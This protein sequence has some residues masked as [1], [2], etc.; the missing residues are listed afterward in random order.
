MLPTFINVA[1]FAAFALQGALADFTIDTPTF[2]QCQSAQVTWS[3]TKA[4]YNLVI[5]AAADPCG[6]YLAD[7]GD[8]NGTSMT[9]KVALAAGSQVQLS[10]EDASGDEAWSGTIT[11]AQ[12]SDT[13]CLPS[14]G[15]TTPT[16][17]TSPP[18]P[19]S[20]LVVV[21]TT[22]VDASPN[23]PSTVG[24]AGAAGATPS[25]NGAPAIHASMP[26]MILGAL[27]AVVA[28]SL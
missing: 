9:Y 8:H 22:T 19:G 12:S 1:L 28:T 17:T 18:V 24:A 3:T 20:T 21:P 11:V 25:S 23:P 16:T 27:A 14:N 26:I 5:V 10:L 7:L 4:P 13:S 6:D 2:T 15:A